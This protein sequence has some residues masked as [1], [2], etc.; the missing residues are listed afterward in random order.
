MNEQEV[1]V[2][3]P[4]CGQGIE[5]TAAAAVGKLNCPTCGRAFVVPRGRSKKVGWT[6]REQRTLEERAVSVER[7]SWVMFGICGICLVGA[8][9]GAVGAERS[10]EWLSVG[11]GLFGL[12]YMTNLIGQ[13]LHIRAALDRK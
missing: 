4:A 5:C 7:A 2:E 6:G 11:G 12:G 3:C 8:V 1:R 9:V 13:L 10:G